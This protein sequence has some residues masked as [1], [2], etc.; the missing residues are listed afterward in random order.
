MQVFQG[1]KFTTGKI[2]LDDTRFIKCSFE[3]CTLRY[4]GGEF[5]WEDCHVG[6]NVGLE[7]HGAAERA[8]IV[9]NM[10]GLMK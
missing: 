1:K 2:D 9:F 4:G 3:R 7:I 10:F 6:E 8:R 5:E